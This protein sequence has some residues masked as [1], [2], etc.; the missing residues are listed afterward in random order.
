LLVSDMKLRRPAILCRRPLPLSRRA[1]NRRLVHGRQDRDRSDDHAHHAA[2]GH[3]QGVRADARGQEHQ[4]RRRVLSE[5]GSRPE[6]RSETLGGPQG[7][8]DS[9]CGGWRSVGARSRGER[10]GSAAARRQRA[11]TP[12]PNR[13]ER[14]E[15]APFIQP[16]VGNCLRTYFVSPPGEEQ[17]KTVPLCSGLLVGERRH[18]HHHPARPHC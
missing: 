15:L 5:Y 3:Q 18:E 10:C 11:E 4:E 12:P 9:T 8:R 14:D 7:S 2:A 17:H 13:R 16:S 6:R 1:E